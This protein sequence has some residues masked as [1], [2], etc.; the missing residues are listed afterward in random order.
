MEEFDGIEGITYDTKKRFSNSY[1]ALR[2]DDHLYYYQL[3]EYGQGFN[4]EFDPFFKK[5]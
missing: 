2:S 4:F 1:I 5:T 3:Y